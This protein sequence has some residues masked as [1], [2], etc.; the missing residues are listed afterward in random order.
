MP[1]GEPHLCRPL[2]VRLWDPLPAP[3]PRRC[4]LKDPAPLSRR[5]GGLRRHRIKAT[6]W[7]AWRKERARSCPARAGSTWVA[8]LLRG[9]RASD[10]VNGC[11]SVGLR[12]QSAGLIGVGERPKELLRAGA[13]EHQ[14]SSFARD[15][16]SMEV[17]N[18][19]RE[20]DQL[21]RPGTELGGAAV[22]GARST[23]RRATGRWTAVVRR[24]IP[25]PATSPTRCLI[26]PHGART[27]CG[28]GGEHPELD[29]SRAHL[30]VRS[31]AEKLSLAPRSG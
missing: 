13:S 18:P 25:R 7:L 21:A 5:G 31:A 10:A 12:S 27:R 24:A 19:A 22:A 14:R 3:R 20:E 9:Q 30:D 29:G 23:P 4:P 28:S 6:A 11:R 26:A 1:L 17:R 15:D 2:S 8:G 16:A